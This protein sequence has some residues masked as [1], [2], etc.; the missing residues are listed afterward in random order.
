MVQD[1][2]GIAMAILSIVVTIG[3]MAGREPRF[4]DRDKDQ[5]ALIERLSAFLDRYHLWSHFLAEDRQ[6]KH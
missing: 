1:A 6:G 4:I 2:V 3:T 5:L